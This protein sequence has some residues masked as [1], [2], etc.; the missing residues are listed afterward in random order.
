M[1]LFT[2]AKAV[3]NTRLDAARAARPAIDHAVRAW[4]R[5]DEQRGARQAGAVTFFGFLSFF[6]LIALSFA[7]F[8]FVIGWYPSVYA[9]VEREIAEA[10]PG[11]VG[12]GPG[13]INVDRIAAAKTEAGLIGLIGLFIAGT[14]WVDALREALRSMWCQHPTGGRNVVMTK[15]MDAG[16]LVV[17]GLS[18]LATVA[19]SGIATMATSQ[20]IDLA[21]LTEGAP[22]RWTIRVTAAAV[23]V[24][25]SAL[26]FAVM[27]WRLSGMRIPRAALVKGAL[28]GGLAFEILKV[29]A[30]FLLGNTMR[31]PVYATF[32][33]A[34][35]LLVWINFVSRVTLLAA[36][37]TAT[38]AYSDGVVG[39]PVRPEHSMADA[40]VGAVLDSESVPLDEEPESTTQRLKRL[41]PGTSTPAG[42]NG[43]PAANG[44]ANGRSAEREDA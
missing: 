43:T 23:A 31:N 33:V 44:A 2:A 27:F 8:G 1:R 3:V 32:A 16:V 20:L 30:T 40:D 18:L 28:L 7:V 12:D 24:S 36:A 14:A 37:W 38:E 22:L 25:S 41:L 6:P 42:T 17:L 11:F 39:E 21:G 34:V 13:Q 35:G 19:L 5:F 29:F 26:L 9:D 15:L 10:L 4:K